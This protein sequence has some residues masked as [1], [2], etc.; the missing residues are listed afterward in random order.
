M[1]TGPESSGSWFIDSS[2]RHGWTALGEERVQAER[3]PVRQLPRRWMVERRPAWITGNRGTSR[4]YE[5]L[6]AH[7]E[8]MIQWAMI[9]LMAGRLAPAPGRRPWPPRAV[10]KSAFRGLTCDDGKQQVESDRPSDR[11][12]V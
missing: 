4:K 8:A 6:P 12:G 1:K 10:A 11:F 5:R 2:S 3:P 9:E 7:A